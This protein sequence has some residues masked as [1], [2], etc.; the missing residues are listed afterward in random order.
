MKGVDLTTVQELMGHKTAA[1]TSRYAHLSPAHRLAAVQKLNPKKAKKRFAQVRPVTE[2][3]G[4]RPPSE[5][6][7]KCL[8]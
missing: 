8:I 5:V 4:G 2:D 3:R 1:M 7:R 6:V